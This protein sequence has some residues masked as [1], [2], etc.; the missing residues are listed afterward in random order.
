M[1]GRRSRL[2]VTRTTSVTDPKF[3]APYCFALLSALAGWEWRCLLQCYRN[4]ARCTAMLGLHDDKSSVAQVSSATR[5][6]CSAKLRG[7]TSFCLANKG[8]PWPLRQ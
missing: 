3:V 1:Q 4:H 6:S 8:S 2:L 7:A 5:E